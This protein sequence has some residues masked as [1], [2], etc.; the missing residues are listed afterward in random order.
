[1]HQLLK[2]HKEDKSL[3]RNGSEKKTTASIFKFYRKEILFFPSLPL[4]CFSLYG[5]WSLMSAN[6]SSWPQSLEMRL[7]SLPP[8][9]S[10]ASGSLVA[11]GEAK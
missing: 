4:L 10:L 9:R 3:E 11:K 7:S 2:I 1:M 6:P 8:S 5:F